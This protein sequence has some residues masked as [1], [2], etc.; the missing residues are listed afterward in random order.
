MTLVLLLCS[1]IVCQLS[2]RYIYPWSALLHL[3][4]GAVV[5]LL[6]AAVIVTKE[7]FI[8]AFIVTKVKV[9]WR[10]IKGD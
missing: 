8:L 1:G 7:E 9:G 6:T 3:V 2:E 4:L 10:K 5:F